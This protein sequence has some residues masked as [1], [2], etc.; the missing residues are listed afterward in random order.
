MEHRILKEVIESPTKKLRAMQDDIGR[1][2]IVTIIKGQDKQE[3]H[4]QTPFLMVG[5][6]VPALEEIERQ[7]KS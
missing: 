7:I 4:F 3:M 5:K 6:A 1:E 2:W